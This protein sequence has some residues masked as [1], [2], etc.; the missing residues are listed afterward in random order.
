MAEQIIAYNRTLWVT[1]FMLAVQWAG[2]PQSQVI[3][4]VTM[5]AEEVTPRVRQG[6]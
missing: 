6:L 5:F 3:D 2:M 4:T 1:V